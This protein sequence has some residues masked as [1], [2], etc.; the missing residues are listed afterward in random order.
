[1]KVIIII[2]EGSIK[3]KGIL[4]CKHMIKLIFFIILINLVIFLLRK[5]YQIQDQQ[6]LLTRTYIKI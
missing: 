4:K 1:M 5:H 3:Y 2:Y 6:I